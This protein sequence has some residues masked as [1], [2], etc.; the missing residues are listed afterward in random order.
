MRS[1]ISHVRDSIPDNKVEDPT[2]LSQSSK[3]SQDS[4]HDIPKMVV[5]AMSEAKIS[6][7]SSNKSLLG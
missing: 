6:V 2:K 7:P 5:K 4:K 1:R 3:Q